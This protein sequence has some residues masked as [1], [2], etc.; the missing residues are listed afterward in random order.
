[1]GLH[2]FAIVHSIPQDVLSNSYKL[3]SDMLCRLIGVVYLERGLKSACQYIIEP[4][5]VEFGSK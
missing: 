4:L 2:R 3:L 5:A 1:M